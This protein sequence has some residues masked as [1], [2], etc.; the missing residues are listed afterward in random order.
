MRVL[1]IDTSCDE[2]SVAVVEQGRILASVVFGQDSLHQ[3]FGGVVPEIASRAHVERMVPALTDA[4]GDTGAAEAVAVTNRPG[5]VGPLLVGLSAAK[6]FAYAHG[7]PL[8]GV[9]HLEAHVA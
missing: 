3:P 1:G 9:N 2:T 6:A 7:L 5:L 4:L 8:I